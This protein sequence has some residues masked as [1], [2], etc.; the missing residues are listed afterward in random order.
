MKHVTGAFS[1]G[2]F[3][4]WYQMRW[5][6]KCW[7]KEARE[8]YQQYL[9]FEAWKTKRKA[10]L[11]GIARTYKILKEHA[12]N[13]KFLLIIISALI[14]IAHGE[15]A[16]LVTCLAFSACV[17]EIRIQILF[18]ER[19][20]LTNMIKEIRQLSDTQT[21]E[22][23]ALQRLNRE[24]KADVRTLTAKIEILQGMSQQ[25]ENSIKTQTAKIETLQGVTREIKTD[26]RTLTNEIETLQGVTREIKTDVRTLTNEIETLQG[27]TREIKTDVRTQ[28]VELKEI[29][30]G[31]GLGIFI[32]ILSVIVGLVSDV[33]LHLLIAIHE[34]LTGFIQ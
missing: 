25:V 5:A 10:V 9:Q 4:K 24:V 20:Q 28:S 33:F 29:A 23:R 12:G 26:V 22:I 32:S 2:F 17:D 18:K 27:V 14:S 13:I 21:I 7:G 31:T 34:W 3:M 11:G 19:R 16:I 30:L 8:R 15:V 1:K 6:Q